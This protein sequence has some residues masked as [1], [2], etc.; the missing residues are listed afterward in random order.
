MGSYLHVSSVFCPGQQ[1]RG[2]YTDWTRRWRLGASIKNQLPFP[3]LIIWLGQT[4][5]TV[6][7]IEIIV[8]GAKQRANYHTTQSDI[9]QCEASS[10]DTTL[11]IHIVYITAA[12][13]LYSKKAG[14]LQGLN[15]RQLVSNARSKKI[16][17]ESTGALLSK[18]TK[19]QKSFSGW[20]LF[21][22]S[23]KPV[24]RLQGVDTEHFWKWVTNWGF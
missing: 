17:S 7:E 14:E 6:A 8:L 13:E 16:A 10:P 22:L 20:K 11:H 12:L 2:T 24:D 4:K 21:V 1:H 19:R 18:P 5:G 15:K 9:H 23:W 3:S